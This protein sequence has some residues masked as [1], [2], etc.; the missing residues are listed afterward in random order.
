MAEAVMASLIA[1]HLY[2]QVRKLFIRLDVSGSLPVEKKEIRF[3]GALFFI[4]MLFSVCKT[5]VGKFPMGILWIHIGNLV[6][7]SFLAFTD[8]KTKL[9]DVPVLGYLFLQNVFFYIIHCFINGACKAADLR[10]LGGY[11]AIV[12]F[13]CLTKA[14]AIGDG[15]IYLA[16]LPIMLIMEDGSCLFLLLYLLIPLL[17]FLVAESGKA[18]LKKHLNTLLSERKPFAPYLLAG[19]VICFLTYVKIVL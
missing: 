5:D 9:L 11:I 17:L 4:T 12:I 18:I 13:C 3:F 1:I 14:F 15:C 7:L 16:M 8:F 19:Y 10:I 2:I 6:I